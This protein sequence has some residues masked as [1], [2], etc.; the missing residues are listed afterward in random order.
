M[1]ASFLLCII[2]THHALITED[3]FLTDTKKGAQKSSVHPD[4]SL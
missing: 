3:A 1:Y 2:P 4:I